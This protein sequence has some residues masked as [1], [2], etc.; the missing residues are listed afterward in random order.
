MKK[1]LLLVT[2]FCCSALAVQ[3]QT[4]VTFNLNL[5][6]ML[7]DSV[8]VPGRDRVQITGNF[9]PL[10]PNK[11]MQMHDKAP[12]DSVYTVEINFSGRFDNQELIYNF[13]I[14]TPEEKYTEDTPRLLRLQGRE[15]EIPPL[16]F[17][18]FA[19]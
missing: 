3:A 16:Y 12:V 8:F 18:S 10:G 7:E 6:Q 9:Y 17:N 4:S 15:I 14:I 2:L 5:Q 13:E 11:F 19:M 1:I